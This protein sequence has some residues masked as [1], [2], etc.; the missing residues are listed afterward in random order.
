V[1]LVVWVAWAAWISKKK[2]PFKNL[3]VDVGKKNQKIVLSSMTDRL[4]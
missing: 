4:N 2:K 1:A 3:L